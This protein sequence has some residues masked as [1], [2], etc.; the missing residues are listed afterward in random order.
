MN[1]GA[2]EFGEVRLHET[3]GSDFEPNTN[4]PAHFS[5]TAVLGRPGLNYFSVFVT[6]ANPIAVNFTHYDL[7][8]QGGWT[9]GGAALG[10]V[11]P[12]AAFI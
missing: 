6:A 11:V 2:G 12:M 10:P 4:R 3:V 7:F 8:L 9:N 5:E 1:L